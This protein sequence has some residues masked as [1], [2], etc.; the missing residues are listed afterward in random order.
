[1]APWSKRSK[2]QF[3]NANRAA[4]GN[5]KN[6][7]KISR[8][9]LIAILENPEDTIGQVK[10]ILEANRAGF[11]VYTDIRETFVNVLGSL[12]TRNPIALAKSDTSLIQSLRM[13]LA[14]FNQKGL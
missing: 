2:S 6:N 8:E 3:R 11:E 12:A 4:S 9:V 10:K 5:D 7:A 14:A 13:M 1:M